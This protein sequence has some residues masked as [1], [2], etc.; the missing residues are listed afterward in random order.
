M[1]LI[2]YGHKK[3]EDDSAPL[4]YINY[5]VNIFSCQFSRMREILPIGVACT[6]QSDHPNPLI[7]YSRAHLSKI[8]SY[9][10]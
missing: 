9:T 5:C 10:K 8:P 4:S 1:K 2:V 3:F 7:L 6:V